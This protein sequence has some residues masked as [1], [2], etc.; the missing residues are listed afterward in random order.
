MTDREEPW[1]AARR[2]FTEETGWPPPEGR[3]LDLGVATLR[4]GKQVQAWA[5]EGNLD[6]AEFRPGTFTMEWPPLSGRRVQFP[7]VDRI[8]WCAPDEARR[9]LNPSQAVFIDRL[10]AELGNQADRPV[11]VDQDKKR[12][13]P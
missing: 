2:E 5:V 8:A 13:D 9:L 11:V 7:E 4:S 6:P 10:L 3:S 12:R 1:S